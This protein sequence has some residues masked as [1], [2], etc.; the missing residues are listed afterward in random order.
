[1]GL[2]GGLRVIPLGNRIEFSIVIMST[3][4][5]LWYTEYGSD[6]SYGQKMCLCHECP[7]TSLHLKSSGHGLRKFMPFMDDSIWGF[8][9]SYIT[10]R[11]TEKPASATFEWVSEQPRSHEE[12]SC[13]A[14]L[15]VA[16]VHLLKRETC[17]V[18]TREVSC[19]IV[20]KGE[21]REFRFHFSV[22][23]LSHTPTPKYVFNYWNIPN[24]FSV[25]VT[26]I[27]RKVRESERSEKSTMLI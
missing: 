14:M 15:I 26:L 3:L 22:Y 2:E 24:W 11:F 21:V 1:M 9:W 5:H 6:G 23:N 4:I 18:R 12:T 25:L 13:W 20:C 27:C 16:D 7:I 10:F 19:G 17:E 8:S